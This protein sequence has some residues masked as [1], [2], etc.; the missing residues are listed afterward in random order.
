MK[1]H[2]SDVGAVITWPQT[3]PPRM[4]H[5]PESPGTGLLSW[6]TGQEALLTKSRGK[7]NLSHAEKSIILPDRRCISIEL[8]L[9]N[10]TETSSYTY[11]AGC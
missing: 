8:A 1:A 5:E 6:S 4:I 9:L 7:C 10:S 11:L 3:A 2:G